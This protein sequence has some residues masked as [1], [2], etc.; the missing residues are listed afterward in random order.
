M[1]DYSCL[2]MPIG[3]AMLIQRSVRTF[4]PVTPRQGLAELRGLRP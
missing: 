2:S 1:T 4:K 3:E